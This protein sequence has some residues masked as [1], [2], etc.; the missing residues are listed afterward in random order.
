MPPLSFD[1]WLSEYRGEIEELYLEIEALFP[2]F[3]AHGDRQSLFLSIAF[4]VYEEE[5]YYQ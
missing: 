5:S 3:K 1:E 4:C 2:S